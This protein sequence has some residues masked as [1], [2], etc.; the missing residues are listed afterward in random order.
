MKKR[1]A[2]HLGVNESGVVKWVKVTAY[3]DESY[4]KAFQDCY[5]AIDNLDCM[6]SFECYL[7]DRQTKPFKKLLDSVYSK[8][9][10][11]AVLNEE[12]VR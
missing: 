5:R 2:L 7:K 6:Q 9:L 11:L 12:T 1:S 3:R 10:V 4:E 8:E